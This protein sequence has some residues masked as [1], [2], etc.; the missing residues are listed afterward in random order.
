MVNTFWHVHV[1]AHRFA[2]LMQ[3]VKS[4]MA[5]PKTAAAAAKLMNIDKTSDAWRFLSPNEQARLEA[6]AAQ[7]ASDQGEYDLNVEEI[8]REVCIPSHSTS[9]FTSV[10]NR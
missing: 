4:S 2:E 3:R 9:I 10:L 7:A 1:L 5:T 8:V 6:Q